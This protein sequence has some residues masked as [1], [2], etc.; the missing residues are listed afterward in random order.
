LLSGKHPYNLTVI[1]DEIDKAI[2]EGATRADIIEYYDLS[3]LE[4]MMVEF[5]EQTYR[6]AVYLHSIEEDSLSDDEAHIRLR[7]MFPM[8]GDP[9]DT[10]Y[11]QGEDRWLS[12]IMRGR[13]DEFRTTIGAERMIALVQKYSTYNAC[14]RALIRKGLI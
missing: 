12:P 13:V 9:T 5:S 11:V 8:Y 6:Y 10:T 14:V 7:K 1:Y 2:A 3:F 4:K